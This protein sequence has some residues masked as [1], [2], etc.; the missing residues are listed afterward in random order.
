MSYE[1]EVQEC[2]ATDAPLAYQVAYQ[3]FDCM[4]AEA[5]KI[6]AKADAEIAQLRAKLEAAE[7]ELTRINKTIGHDGAGTAD[8]VEKEWHDYMMVVGECTKVY[9][10]FSG[11]TKPNTAAEHVIAYGDERQN[12]RI[13]EAVKEAEE[14]LQNALAAAESRAARA[15]ELLDRATAWIGASPHHDDKS[16]DADWKEIGQLE[17]DI[18]QHLADR[19]SGKEGV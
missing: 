18:A 5:R 19:E 13:D 1:K 14:M 10:H 12:D 11:L 2:Y 8:Q 4:K 17:R 16:Y 9:E 3:G 7:R 6:A 15:D